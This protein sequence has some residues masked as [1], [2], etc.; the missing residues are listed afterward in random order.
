MHEFES[1]E[2]ILCFK[3]F[4]FRNRPEFS[5]D[6]SDVIMI[7]VGARAGFFFGD[8]GGFDEVIVFCADV[9][10]EEAD[11]RV[12]IGGVY[13]E[14]AVFAFES[15]FAEEALVRIFIV[16]GFALVHGLMTLEAAHANVHS[17]EL[18]YFVV[19]LSAVALLEALF[20]DG[21]ASFGVAVTEVIC[22]LS[23]K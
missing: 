9:F 22:P 16:R 7:G 3:I 21:V 14:V 1:L 5:K 19:V 23:L 20:A 11:F 15:A 6:D 17:R 12:G 13:V 4:L 8:V 10:A 18:L 2:I